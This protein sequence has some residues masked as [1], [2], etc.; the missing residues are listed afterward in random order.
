MPALT[1][2]G[3]KE[4]HVRKHA[5]PVINPWAVALKFAESYVNLNRKIGLLKSESIYLSLKT[6]DIVSD[7]AWGRK[8]HTFSEPTLLVNKI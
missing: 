1:K 4:V 3:Y 7:G 6:T 2:F 8:P 5:V